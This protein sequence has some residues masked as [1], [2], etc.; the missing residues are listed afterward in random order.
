MHAAAH[1]RARLWLAA[2]ACLAAMACSQG[3]VPP[4]RIPLK[5][6]FL[7]NTAPGSRR[8]WSIVGTHLSTISIIETTASMSDALDALDAGTVDLALLGGDEVY[9]AYLKGTTANATP[10]KHLRGV[11]QLHTAALHVLALPHSHIET[12]SDLRGKRLAG[13][14]LGRETIL[15][16]LLTQAGLTPADIHFTH[17]LRSDAVSAL[18]S[19]AIDAF[20]DFY[21]VVNDTF[22]VE[23]RAGT[24]ELVAVAPADTMSARRQYP[25]LHS[26]V[27]PADAY[28][29]PTDV[30]TVGINYL[31]VC[32]EGLDKDVV[33]QLTRALFEAIPELVDLRPGLRVVSLKSASAAPIPL[34]PGASRFYRERQLF[35]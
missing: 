22:S 26:D 24:L 14:Q 8:I 16:L 28:G 13:P 31:F 35:D 23:L 18:K 20:F 12:L 9:S 3:S 30:P 1:A 7:P 21:P 19:G 11:A 17:L 6:A 4:P 34:H 15:T 5:F 29:L 27:I 10:H 2:A 33:Y 25:Y 32:R